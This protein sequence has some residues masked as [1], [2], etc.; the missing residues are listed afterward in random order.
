MWFQFL[1][2]QNVTVTIDIPSLIYW[3]IIGTIAG[4]LASVLVR[5]ARYGLLASIVL[6]LIGAI[7]GGFLFQAIGVAR[8]AWGAINIPVTDIVAAFVGAFL[9]LLV[10]GGLGRRYFR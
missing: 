3:T 9:V 6:G 10:F 2:F 5:G 4:L 7:V 8:D 1:L